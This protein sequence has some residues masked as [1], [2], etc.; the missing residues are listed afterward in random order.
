MTT[1]GIGQMLTRR[2]AQ[3]G[4]DHVH[5]HRFRHT[6]ASGWLSGGGNEGDLMQLAGWKSRDMLDRYGASAAAARARDAHK[7]MSPGDL[8]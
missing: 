8:L 3:A 4:V 1:S 2:G 6:F 7:R 5:P